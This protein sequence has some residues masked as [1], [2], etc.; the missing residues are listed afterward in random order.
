[1]QENCKKVIIIICSY[2][3]LTVLYHTILYYKYLIS[4]DGVFNLPLTA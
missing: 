4:P 1:M 3:T 2:L